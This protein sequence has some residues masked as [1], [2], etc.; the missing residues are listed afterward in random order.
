MLIFDGDLPI[1]SLP[2]NVYK[3]L[4]NELDANSDWH[5]LG[6]YVSEELDCFG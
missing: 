3:E 5:I 4:V 2:A 1:G 6:Q